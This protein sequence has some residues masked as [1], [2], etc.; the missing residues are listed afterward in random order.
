MGV[1]GRKVLIIE[2]DD[3][4]RPALERLLNAAGWQ[5][6]A[7]A[8]VEA[9]PAGAEK[10]ACVIC[11][12]KLPAMSG[13]GLLTEWRAQGKRTPVIL[14]TAYDRPGLREEAM[15]RG[16]AACLVKPFRGTALLEAINAVSG[17]A[18]GRK[19]SGNRLPPHQGSR[20]G[21]GDTDPIANS[22]IT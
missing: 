7:C 1:T 15:R 14:I 2:D 17:P 4:L 9:L 5:T 16:A 3:S 19:E 11:D 12:L 8:S 22:E 18:I 6:V 21:H 13:F 10:A 20:G